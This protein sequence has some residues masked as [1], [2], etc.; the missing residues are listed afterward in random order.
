MD[1]ITVCI[2]NLNASIT[3]PACLEALNFQEIEPIKAIVFDNGSFDG[4]VELIEARIK[5][6]WFKKVN[7]SIL[8][9]TE[10]EGGKTVNI[11]FLRYKICQAVTTPYLMFL[12]ADVLLPPHAILPC[13]KKVKADE[14]LACL[15]IRYEPLADHVQMGATVWRTE[16][17]RQVKWMWDARGCDCRSALRHLDEAG[18]KYCYHEGLQAR[19]VKII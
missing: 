12:D 7:L 19:H 1:E 9:Q 18:L 3:L 10:R 17:A 13:L 2:P 11:A 14:K 5:N 6:N 15:G 4:S 16:I 8:K